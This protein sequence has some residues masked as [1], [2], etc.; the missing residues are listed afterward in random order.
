MGIRILSSFQTAEGF[1]VT[2]V[3]SRI[4]FVSTHLVSNIVTFRQEFSLTRDFRLDAKTISSVPFT[5]D[6]V[7]F[8]ATSFPT[9]DMVYFHLKRHLVRLGLVVEDV[10]EEGQ[11]PS[12]YTEPDEVETPAHTGAPGLIAPEPD[13]VPPAEP[14]VVE[15][16]APTT[17]AV[18]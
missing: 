5:T 15:P 12:T 16:E 4:V 14:P 6:T 8:Q 13:I 18:E 10:L 2:E 9:V 3:Y 11:A 7:S 17:P 1:Q